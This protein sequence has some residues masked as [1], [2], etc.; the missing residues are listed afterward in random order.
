MG[1]IDWNK[2]KKVRSTEEHNDFFSSDSGVAGTYMPNMSEE[3]MLKWKGKKFIK[4]DNPRVEIRKTMGSNVLI[5]VSNKEPFIQLSTNGK[6]NMS[7]QV[8]DEFVEAINEAREILKRE[9]K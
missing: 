5:I 9:V 3:D 8:F 6:I 4:T 2:P 7:E 1:V